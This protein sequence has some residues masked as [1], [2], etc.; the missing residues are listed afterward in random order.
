MQIIELVKLISGDL[1]FKFYG[2]FL[3]PVNIKLAQ[4]RDAEQD[5][6]ELWTV[7]GAAT[8]Q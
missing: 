3:Q 1:A 7:E 5:L 8:S 6:L 2:I 4:G